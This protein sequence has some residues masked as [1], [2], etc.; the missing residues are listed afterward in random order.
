MLEVYNKVQSAI[1]CTMIVD[2]KQLAQLY[3]ITTS[4]KLKKIKEKISRVK[5]VRHRKYAVTNL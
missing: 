5:T 2:K 1:C 4:K 3:L